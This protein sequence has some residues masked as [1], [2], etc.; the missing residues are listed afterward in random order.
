MPPALDNL[1]LKMAQDFW[2]LQAAGL[3]VLEEN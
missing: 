1:Q 3:P 2:V